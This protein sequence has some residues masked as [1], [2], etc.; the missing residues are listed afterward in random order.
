MHMALIAVL[1]LTGTHPTLDGH[2][3]NLRSLHERVRTDWE[4]IRAASRGDA[5]A[6]MSLDSAVADLREAK[7]QEAQELAELFTSSRNLPESDRAKLLLT[8]PSPA[9]HERSSA[10]CPSTSGRDGAWLDGT[11]D[12]D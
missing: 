1:A 8:V 7:V 2:A 3:A 6:A 9:D 11:F 4:T 10:R 5:R 12:G